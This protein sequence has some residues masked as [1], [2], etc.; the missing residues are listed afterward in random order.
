ME[1][2]VIKLNAEKPDARKIK[3]AAELLDA[4]RL[5]VFPT[6]TVYGIGCKATADSLAKLDKIKKRRPEKCYTLHIGRKEDLQKYVPRIPIRAK[7]LIEKTWPGPV[8][9]VFQLGTDDIEK[10]KDSLGREAFEALYTDN[11]IGIRCP[12][13]R[14]AS[15]LLSAAK[16]P[17]VAPSANM[18]GQQPPAN[19]EQILAQLDGQVDLVLDGGSCRLKK[20]S[21]VVE[22]GKTGWHLLRQGV[23][24][25]DQIEAMS[26]VNILFVCVGNTCRSPM[27]EGLCRKFLAEKLECELDTLDNMGYKI[28]SA[29]VMAAAD[30]PASP[31]SVGFC[32]D[33]GIDI[34]GHRSRFVTDEM[35]E[36]SDYIF[37]MSQSHRENIVARRP[38]AAQKCRLLVDGDDIADP[39]GGARQIYENC[40]KKIE[41]GVKKIVSEF[42]L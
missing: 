9:I 25:I 31:D 18:A 20:S 26:T 15:I 36:E 12:D 4:G 13:N 35:L 1:T 16:S 17:I 2:K 38:K 10:Q 14:I 22:I 40:G 28:G 33:K 21:T 39:I 34:T 29:G 19:A 24:T 27:A 11:S 41:L 5:V 23:Y 42:V 3:N 7:K 32:A 30:L 6:E 8:T 37:V